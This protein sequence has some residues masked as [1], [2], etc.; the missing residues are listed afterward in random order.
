LAGEFFDV[1]TVADLGVAG[2]SSCAAAG[3]VAEDQVEGG[4]G[5]GLLCRVRYFAADVFGVGVAAEACGGVGETPGA[6]VGGEDVG[7]REAMRGVWS[8]WVGSAA[9]ASSATRREP[10]SICGMA[11]LG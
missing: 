11:L 9:A 4:R 10:S 6:D 5:G 8:K 3:D 1:E 2:Q 7:V